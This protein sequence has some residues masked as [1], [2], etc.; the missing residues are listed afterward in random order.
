LIADQYLAPDVRDKISVLLQADKSGLTSTDFAD[1]A[2][3][4]DR[5]RD[6]DRNTTREH[7]NQ[8]HDWH[9]ANIELEDGDIDAACFGHPA[10]DA[11]TPASKGPARDCVV[12]KV[13]EFAAELRSP[14][15]PPDERLE[16]LQFLLHFVGDL[17]QPL[18]AADDHDEGG[19]KKRVSAR[20]MSAGNLHQYWDTEFVQQLGEDPA[21]VARDL[22]GR[23]TDDQVRQWS[24]GSPSDWALESFALARDRAYGLLPPPGASGSY[25]LS[26][27]YVRD[28]SGVVAG[29]LSKAGVRLAKLLN[30]ALH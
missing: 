15:T 24:Q 13:I 27:C 26:S 29:Q 11:N 16:A 5:F 18:H 23:I 20:G 28:A 6:S 7:Y 12:D 9:Y 25:R 19:N 10:L 21:Q 4:A 1:E 17:H 2:T 14:D 8:T 22:V 3:W 30:D